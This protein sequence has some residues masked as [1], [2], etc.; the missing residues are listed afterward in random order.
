MHESVERL[1]L[2]LSA[3]PG[4]PGTRSCIPQGEGMSRSGVCCASERGIRSRIPVLGDEIEGRGARMLG[5]ESLIEDHPSLSAVGLLADRVRRRMNGK[6]TCFY[7][8]LPID[9][10]NVC[11][12]HRCYTSPPKTLPLLPATIDW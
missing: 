8:N 6:K 2:G 10:I 4:L 5:P 1:L 9:Y 12:Y 7:F 3:H 11:E